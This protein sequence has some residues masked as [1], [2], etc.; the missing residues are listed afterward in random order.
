M[1]AAM[2]FCFFKRLKNEFA[3]ALVNEPSVFELRNFTVIYVE[4][5][6]RLH[7]LRVLKWD[8]FFFLFASY[9]VLWTMY[10]FQTVCALKIKGRRPSVPRRV[11]CQYVVNMSIKC[12]LKNAI[13]GMANSHPSPLS[14]P[15]PSL[16][17]PPLIKHSMGL[18]K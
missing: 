4:L 16:K 17:A 5:Y 12:M 13:K 11:K 9:F 6:I 2:G 10:H 14:K 8:T 7:A 15:L 3:I 1:S 18:F